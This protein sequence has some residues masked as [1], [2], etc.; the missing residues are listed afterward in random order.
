MGGHQGAA[1][2]GAAARGG[3]ASSTII[4]RETTRDGASTASGGYVAAGFGGQ[5]SSSAMYVAPS[6]T[7]REVVGGALPVL[8][9]SR[10]G[11]ANA[12]RDAGFTARC[13][14]RPHAVDHVAGGSLAIN[15]LVPRRVELRKNGLCGAD[16][17]SG[18]HGAFTSVSGPRRDPTAIPKNK[19]P[20]DNPWAPPAPR[21]VTNRLKEE[22]RRGRGTCR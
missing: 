5:Q 19:L 4:M 8:T 21:E 14:D 7:M 3:Q 22:R 6:K 16:G 10:P 9:G 18:A 11:A 1:Y 20:V 12:R 2:A 17:T 15:E 13:H